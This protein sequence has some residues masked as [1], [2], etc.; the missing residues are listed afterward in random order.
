MRS[1][2]KPHKQTNAHKQN[3]WV[4]NII[5]FIG[6]P[7]HT[8]QQVHTMIMICH[9]EAIFVGFMSFSEGTANGQLMSRKHHATVDGLEQ[10]K[11]APKN[12]YRYCKLHRVLHMR[13]N[14]L[15]AVAME[16]FILSPGIA[17]VACRHSTALGWCCAMLNKLCTILYLYND[18]F[19]FH[20][21]CFFFVHASA[22]IREA[23]VGTLCHGNISIYYIFEYS[24]KLLF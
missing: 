24:S 7:S 6:V 17:P 9:C 20:V 23:A 14:T 22:A 19:L 2:A 12:W 11:S 5:I 13:H 4:L 3:V 10:G 16:G 21:F 18:I 1:I 8:T 15:C